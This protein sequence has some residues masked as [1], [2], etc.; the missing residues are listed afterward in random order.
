MGKKGGNASFPLADAVFKPGGLRGR[1]GAAGYIAA[2][3][4]F[5]E[6]NPVV[7]TLDNS[8]MPRIMRMG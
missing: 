2:D 5:C 8:S 3:T 7:D 6:L 1:A 4:G